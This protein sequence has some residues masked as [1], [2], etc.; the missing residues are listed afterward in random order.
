MGDAATE[1]AIKLMQ[2]EE[3]IASSEI[4]GIVLSDK[5]KMMFKLSTLCPDI[6]MKDLQ[7]VYDFMQT[8]TPEQK[9]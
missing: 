7:A 3:S 1:L 5:D 2:I 6:S 8:T 4:E 9:D